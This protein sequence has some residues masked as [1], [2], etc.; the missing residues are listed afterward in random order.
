MD[1]GTELTTSR[2]RPLRILSVVATTL[3]PFRC[4]SH[5]MLRRSSWGNICWMRSTSASRARDVRP[6][7]LG[8]VDDAGEKKK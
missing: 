5:R 1:T 3:P 6:G 7:A 2:P 8:S 4:K